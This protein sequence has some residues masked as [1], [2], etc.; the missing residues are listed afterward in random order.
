MLPIYAYIIC[1]H[2]SFIFS[3]FH[4]QRIDGTMSRILKTTTKLA[5]NKAGATS[6]VIN[7]IEFSKPPCS[8]GYRHV[9]AV[10]LIN[11]PPKYHFI[12]TSTI[13]HFLELF[14]IE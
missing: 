9:I 8:T 14:D 10:R 11:L 12:I 4:S 3:F 6:R 1:S 13:N 5:R 7:F 2:T